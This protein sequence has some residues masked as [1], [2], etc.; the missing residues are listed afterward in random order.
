MVVAIAFPDDEQLQ[1]GTIVV[2]RNSDA[3]GRIVVDD[4]GFAKVSG[5]QRVGNRDVSF[6]TFYELMPVLH[7][8]WRLATDEE[9]RRYFDADQ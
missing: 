5:K 7:Q 6:S 8:N 3:I 2:S 1:N 9:V 4:V